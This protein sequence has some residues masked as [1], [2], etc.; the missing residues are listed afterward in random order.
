MGVRTSLGDMAPSSL[1]SA[2][3][4][5]D[6]QINPMIP[7]SLSVTG[8]PH[9]RRGAT[10]FMANNCSSLLVVPQAE[11][12]HVLRRWAVPSSAGYRQGLA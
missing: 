2:G 4:Q 9:N 5:L 3:P 6:K 12:G 1:F 8:F 7:R 10:P 11:G